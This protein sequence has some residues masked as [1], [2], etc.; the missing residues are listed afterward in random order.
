MGAKGMAMG[1][2]GKLGAVAGSAT[3]KYAPVA[4]NK[5]KEKMK[6]LYDKAK[7]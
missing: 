6:G 7:S 3:K 4:Y 2:A 5:A 1:G